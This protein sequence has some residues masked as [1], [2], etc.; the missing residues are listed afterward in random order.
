[1]QLQH[2]FASTAA[3]QLRVSNLCEAEVQE[4]DTQIQIQTHV[5]FSFIS[6]CGALSIW[7]CRV[8]PL[9][10]L[11]SL[12]GKTNAPFPGSRRGAQSEDTLVKHKHVGPA[13]ALLVCPDPPRWGLGGP[14]QS[15]ALFWEGSSLFVSKQFRI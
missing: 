10:T 9:Q 2:V 1:M 4:K 14:V 12:F 11:R 6:P 13:V 15:S 8:C 7:L 5:N 3:F